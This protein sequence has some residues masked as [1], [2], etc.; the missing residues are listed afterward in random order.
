MRHFLTVLFLM[1]GASLSAQ[2]VVEKWGCAELTFR[3]KTKKNPFDV[4]LEATFTNGDKTLTVKGFYDGDDTFR[5]RFMPTSEG[6]WSYSTHSSER[7]LNRQRG[8]I[9][10]TAP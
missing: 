6:Q 2:T 8:V 7:P 4:T 1:I 5:I 10:A 3:H 9:T